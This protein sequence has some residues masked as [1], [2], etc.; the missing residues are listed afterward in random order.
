M[1]TIV[2]PATPTG[3][4]IAIVRVSGEDAFHIVESSFKVNLAVK[5]GKWNATLKKLKIGDEVLDECI[6]LTMPAPKS[7]TGENMVEIHSHGSSF[8]VRKIVDTL[9]KHGA[10]A[11][12][13]GEFTKRAVLNG[14]MSILQAEAINW[15]IRSE[16]SKGWEIA[17]KQLE[18]EFEAVIRKLRKGI[19]DLASDMVADLDFSDQVELS[20]D[21]FEKK[22]RYVLGVLEKIVKSLERSVVIFNETKVVIAGRPNAGKSSLMNSL[23]GRDRVIVS[24]IEG[25]TRDFVSETVNIGGFRIRL[26]DTAGIRLNASDE[27]EREGIRKAYREIEGATVL[28]LVVDLERGFGDYEKNVLLSAN[29]EIIIVLNKSDRVDDSRI[30]EVMESVTTWVKN[31]ELDC[32][33]VN[34][35]ITVAKDGIIHEVVDKLKTILK[36]ILDVEIPVVPQERYLALF[37][38][39]HKRAQEVVDAVRNGMLDAASFLLEEIVRDLEF[40]LGK[41]DVEEVLDEVF[42]KFCIGK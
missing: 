13:P 15:L 34:F 19:I 32:G 7:Y 28:L 25:T 17:K 14:K 18:G 36:G 27:V 42:S 10:R 16:N 2:A 21:Y 29:G 39:A 11:A 40:V 41:V 31:E 26:V 1:D 30:S 22:A 37:K 8:I 12:Q 24:D 20:M 3:G 35:A 6:V 4:A 23:L 38:D 9:I 5:D 33:R